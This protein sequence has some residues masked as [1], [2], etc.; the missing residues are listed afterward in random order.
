MRLIFVVV[1]LLLPFTIAKDLSKETINQRNEH[2]HSTFHFSSW[3]Q[4]QSHSLF[5]TIEWF[6]FRVFYC[7][8]ADPLNGVIFVNGERDLCSLISLMCLC[9]PFQIIKRV[10]FARIIENCIDYCYYF[11]A[12]EASRCVLFWIIFS[13]N[14]HLSWKARK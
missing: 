3:F 13:L 1:I 8:V 10:F 9:V 7:Q 2:F 11:E 12:L 6:F 14:W 5:I 4:F